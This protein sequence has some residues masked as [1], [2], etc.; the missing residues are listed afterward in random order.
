MA[1]LICGRWN[2]L[3]IFH[4]TEEQEAYDRIADTLFERI[5]EAET[6]C[7]E[8]KYE[9]ELVRAE[10]T[11]MTERAERA[12]RQLADELAKETTDD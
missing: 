2:C 8:A 11:A 6:R 3:P 9:L 1:C 10:L 5:A 7:A 4:S 12:E